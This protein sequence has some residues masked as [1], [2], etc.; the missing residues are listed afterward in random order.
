MLLLQYQRTPLHLSCESDRVDVV[1]E[2]LSH[3][4]DIHVKNSVSKIIIYFYNHSLWSVY[5]CSIELF[6]HDSSDAPDYFEI[7]NSCFFFF[8]V[9][10]L[11]LFNSWICWIK[12]D[13]YSMTNVS[14]IV[15]VYRGRK[16]VLQTLYWQLLSYCIHNWI[17]HW[18]HTQS[19]KHI[20]CVIKIIW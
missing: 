16:V 17:P 13:F 15:C 20:A 6:H 18:V 2:L 11:C 14:S 1:N 19:L 8:M 4:A 12:V 3:G 5:L 9:L 7:L 10:K